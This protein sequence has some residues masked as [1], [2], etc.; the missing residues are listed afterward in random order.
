VTLLEINNV[1]AQL[2][3][4]SHNELANSKKNSGEKLEIA[5]ALNLSIPEGCNTNLKYQELGA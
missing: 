3:S 1:V 5:A 4:P 2:Q